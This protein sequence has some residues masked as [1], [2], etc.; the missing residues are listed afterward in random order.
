V[1]IKLK[2]QDRDSEHRL[3]KACRREPVEVIPVW[4]MRQAGRYMAEYR[5]LRQKYNILEIIKTPELAVEVTMQPMQA[6][7]L[8]AAIIFADILPLLEGMGLKLTFEKGEGPVIHNPLRTPTDIESLCQPDPRESVG[9]TL[10]AI[11]LVRQ[12]LAGRVPLIGFSGAP[13]TLASY[14]IEGGASRHYILAKSLM[15]EHPAAWHSLM[16]K[17]AGLVGD[18]LYAQAEA[19]AQVLQLFDSWVGALSPPDYQE[20]VLPHSQQTIKRAQESGAPVIHFSTG[21]SAMLPLIK[22][23]GGDVIGVDWRIELSQA[24]K[25]LGN[26]VAIQGNLDPVTLFAPLPVLKQRTADIL[27]QMAGHP[28]FIFNLGHGILPN[29]PVEQVGALVDFVHEY[30]VMREE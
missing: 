18:Y 9:F 14:A 4:L 12:A 13:F 7:N 27:D 23:A 11:R 2:I 19:G 10:E 22:A 17:L 29:T 30:K 28:G 26:D 20:F 24:R 21:T 1:E 16:E 3:L 6:F 25:I 8:D 15:Y 5:A